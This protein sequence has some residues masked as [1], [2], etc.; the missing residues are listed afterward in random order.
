MPLDQPILADGG[1]AAAE[2]ASGPCG[3]SVTTTI[4]TIAAVAEEQLSFSLGSALSWTNAVV[5]CALR[6]LKSFVSQYHRTRSLTQSM[7]CGT[8]PSDVRIERFPDGRV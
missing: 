3:A 6:F 1:A 2:E 7:S 5:T 4:G 8:T